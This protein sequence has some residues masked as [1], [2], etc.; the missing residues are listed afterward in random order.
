MGKL[1]NMRLI[2]IFAL[3]LLAVEAGAGDSLWVYP[4]GH[5]QEIERAT[6][7]AI[8]DQAIDNLGAVFTCRGERGWEPYPSACEAKM[9]AAMRAITPFIGSM[10]SI[11]REMVDQYHKAW[12]LWTAAKACWTHAVGEKKP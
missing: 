8:G 9:E 6:P 12:E 1:V 11:S 3:L 2:T 5:G 4:I 7:C 10:P